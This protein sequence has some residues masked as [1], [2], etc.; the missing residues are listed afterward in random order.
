MVIAHQCDMGGRVPGS[1]AADSTEIFQE[2]LRIPPLKLYEK[3][4]PNRTLFGLIRK[5]VRVPDLVTG[6]LE[7]QY[8]TCRIGEREFRKLIDRYGEEALKSYFA[9]L[10]DYGETLTRKAI[11]AWPDG[12]Y[13]FTDYIDDDGFDEQPI[14][15]T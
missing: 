10:I 6:D 14:P 15:I 9:E 3:G 2:G 5:N 1:N 4:R 8:A 7:A 13:S 11:R 12:S